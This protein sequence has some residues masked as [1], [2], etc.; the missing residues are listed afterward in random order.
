MSSKSI[1]NKLSSKI[2]AGSGSGDKMNHYR[3]GYKLML[4]KKLNPLGYFVIFTGY[5]VAIAF[6]TILMMKEHMPKQQVA[7]IDTNLIKTQI[8]E[9]IKEQNIRKQ[10]FSQ[11]INLNQGISK[12]DFVKFKQEM[13]SKVNNINIGYLELIEKNDINTHKQLKQMAVR[14]PASLIINNGKVLTY[15]YENRKILTYKHRQIIKNLKIDLNERKES[16]MTGLNLSS[17]FDQKK[18]RKFQDEID[19]E[20]YAKKREL[21]ALVNKFNKDKYIVLNKNKL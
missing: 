4:T 12:N 11:E 9:E 7:S 15:T 21:E 2:K 16:Y 13:I 1:I 10:G 5:T 8:L 3:P 17:T 6:T 18:L 14:E 20:V 19:F